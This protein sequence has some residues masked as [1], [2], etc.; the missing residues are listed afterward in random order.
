M[1]KTLWLI[2]VLLLFVAIGAPNAHADLFH[3]TFT[4]TGTCSVAPP[5]A[6]N[7]SFPSPTSI[8]ETWFVIGVF[9]APISLTLPATDSP[10]DIYQWQNTNDILA[11][12][13]FI[14]LKI[15]DLNNGVVTSVTETFN[16][17]FARFTDSGNLTFTPVPEPGTVSLMLLGIGLVAAMR[18]RIA[19]G[20]HPAT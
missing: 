8:T 7:V 3:P 16:V 19:Q 14:T 11:T 18:K 13:P 17:S 20:T 5:T 9:T 6:P 4:C 12:P 15:T 1:R 2:P 10:A